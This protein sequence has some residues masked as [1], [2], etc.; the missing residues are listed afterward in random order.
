M[1]TELLEPTPIDD[2]IQSIYDV[3]SPARRYEEQS[4]DVFQESIEVAISGYDLARKKAVD[5]L[6]AEKT[7]NDKDKT[8]DVDAATSKEQG[9]GD[10]FYGGKPNQG[11]AECSVSL[12]DKKDGCVKP[13]AVDEFAGDAENTDGM[14]R[15]GKGGKGGDKAGDLGAMNEDDEKEFVFSIE[16]DDPKEHEDM[17]KE[18]LFD[19]CATRST[20]SGEHAPH[21][22]VQPSPAETVR[23]ADGSMK[24]H[25]G[26]K[27]V[28]KMSM[29]IGPL[30]QGR[31]EVTNTKKPIMAASAPMD[32][33][34]GER[35]HDGGPFL[36][37]VKMAEE[38]GEVVRKK[39]EKQA[40]P[41]H[42]RRGIYVP[43]VEPDSAFALEVKEDVEIE[44]QEVDDAKFLEETRVAMTKPT[45]EERRDHERTHQTFRSCC[46]WCV[47]DTVKEDPY[48]RRAKVNTI[49]EVGVDYGIAGRTENEDFATIL[50]LTTMLLA[51]SGAIQVAKK[52]A[53]EHTT[54]S[55]LDYFD[56][57]GAMDVVLKP[58][59][60]PAIAEIILEVKRRRRQQT[61][62]KHSPAG[63]HQSNG[64]IEFEV[65]R[66]ES[67]IRTIVAG[68]ADKPGGRTTRQSPALSWVARHA[69]FLRTRFVV[70][71]GGRTSWQKIGG[72][73]YTSVLAEI[74]ERVLFRNTDQDL[75]KLDS[76][77]ET[78]AFLG[79]RAVSDEIIVGT[80][81]GAYSA[82][83]FKHKVEK[84]RWSRQGLDDFIGVLWN[85][86]GGA[87]SVPLASGGRKYITKTIVQEHGAT[88]GYSGNAVTHDRRCRARFEK[89]FKEEDQRADS[90]EPVAMPVPVGQEG[91]QREAHR[92]LLIGDDADIEQ[93]GSF[94][95]ADMDVA[96][97]T[98]PPQ[99]AED[100]TGMELNAVGKEDE[101]HLDWE[102][103]PV[104][105]KVVFEDYMGEAF[106]KQQVVDGIRNEP[107]ETNEFEVFGWIDESKVPRGAEVVTT[108]MFHR[109]KDENTVRSR[110]VG[111]RDKADRNY[112]FYAGTPHAVLKLIVSRAAPRGVTRQVGGNDNIMA[113]FHAYPP[114]ELARPGK[115][116]LVRKALY[117]TRPTPRAFQDP[118]NGMFEKNDFYIMQAVACSAYSPT[119]D[120]P[121][122]FHGDEA[123]Y[124]G[125]PKNSDKVED[126]VEKTF[127]SKLMPCASPGAG[128]EAA[129]LRRSLLWSEQGFCQEPDIKYFESSQKLLD[130]TLAKLVPT[131]ILKQTGRGMCNALDI[132]G[133]DEAADYRRGPGILKDV[134]PDRFDLQ[135]AS[136]V[137]VREKL[138]PRAISMAR[139]KRVSRCC[140]G[141]P[142]VGTW[143][144]HQSEVT[145]KTVRVDGDWTGVAVTCRSTSAREVQHGGHTIE[146]R[147]VTQQTASPSS[148][149]S[150]FYA[151]CSGC[152]RGLT[153][154]HDMQETA[155][156][157]SSSDQVDVNVHTD[158]D[159][160]RGNSHRQGCGRSRHLQT[161]DLWHEKAMKESD[162]VEDYVKT[163]ENPVDCDTKAV[164]REIIAC[165]MIRL[166][167]ISR[168]AAGFVK[169]HL[170]V[171]L[172]FLGGIVAEELA[173]AETRTT[174]IGERGDQKGCIT[175][176]VI[177]AVVTSLCWIVYILKKRLDDSKV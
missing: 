17:T 107:S 66:I 119:L 167:L 3:E 126:M 175:E 114:L 28:K 125:E 33:G 62:T 129:L 39:S 173:H 146:T 47:P 123:D 137:L 75:G 49:V 171:A 22:A 152:A 95:S 93:Y 112:E 136:E 149:E 169:K 109:Q 100:S 156:V 124:E 161:R 2:G 10:Y 133:I 19:T 7:L 113:F 77:R 150:E 108:T 11:K 59:Q 71:A 36:I 27:M 177:T 88:D 151:L 141:L 94:L 111:C 128:Q 165:C 158:G 65:S 103:Y 42:K 21:S 46:Y 9:G 122:G 99:D 82:R 154:K 117:G 69:A 35:L 174:A 25:Y 157:Q 116:W 72:K 37:D 155:G 138:K 89:I 142:D 130:A 31:L 50:V 38:I 140:S 41:L 81:D 91:Q 68:L 63:L 12:N 56:L 55:F 121:F 87:M 57:W 164:E 172:A 23:R 145:G 101:Q 52:G 4:G 54:A 162:F 70:R 32:T 131:P 48:K 160:A 166:N 139:P 127:K 118:V 90:T 44:V 16:K 105:V 159:A 110:I 73:E 83:S 97:Q 6:R 58:D 92:P 143:F 134:A 84:D 153:D 85:P 102:Q 1:R 96:P 148:G 43:L 53:D 20:C 26:Q 15:G 61:A 98:P 78:G 86:R 120:A 115:L 40:N 60:E 67:M 170:A 80:I 74:G 132:L 51:A 76:G 13:G 144:P 45:D 18:L 104:H 5:E 163:S 106:D 79:R 8:M 14:R 135:R 64:R 29:D 147:S 30:P 176:I 168:S 34:L 24:E